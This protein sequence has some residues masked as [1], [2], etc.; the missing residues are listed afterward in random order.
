MATRH[1][2]KRGSNQS[3]FL[4]DV[5]WFEDEKNLHSI[6]HDEL[7]FVLHDRVPPPTRHFRNTINASS[8]DGRKR[9]GE[10]GKEELEAGVRQ[11]NN[12]GLAKMGA[13]PENRPGV[14]GGED[15]KDEEGDDLED[16]TGHHQVVAKLLHLG[17]VV[18]GRCRD[19]AARAL[20]DQ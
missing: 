20:E 5:I 15:A 4:C 10:G 13:I 11:Q 1:I 16:N 2:L 19:A 12:S 17:V 9:N 8:K 3:G 18:F 14:T 6:Q 7:P